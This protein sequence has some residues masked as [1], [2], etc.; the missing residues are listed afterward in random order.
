MHDWQLG[1]GDAD[2]RGTITLIPHPTLVIEGRHDT[3]TSARHGKAIAAA[4]PGAQLHILDAVHP[5]NVEQPKAF[6]ERVLDFLA[7]HVAA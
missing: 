6:V 5:A 7:V 4:S 3:V 1:S 2:L